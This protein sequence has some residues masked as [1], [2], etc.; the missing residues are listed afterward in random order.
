MPMESNDILSLVLY[1]KN[2]DV[3]AL[4]KK[5]ERSDNLIKLSYWSHFIFVFPNC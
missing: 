4:K 1:R 3:I 2:S 5:I